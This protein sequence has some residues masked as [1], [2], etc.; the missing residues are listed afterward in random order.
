MGQR[1][2]KRAD[3]RSSRTD[4]ARCNTP[5][6]DAGIEHSVKTHK[7]REIAEQK[8]RYTGH[9]LSIPAD[10]SLGSLAALPPVT[11]PLPTLLDDRP[12]LPCSMQ[13]CHT[14]RQGWHHTMSNSLPVHPSH[15]ATPEFQNTCRRMMQDIVPI[16]VFCTSSMQDKTRTSF[17]K[18]RPM[19]CWI[20]HT[21]YPALALGT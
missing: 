8:T 1:R 3:K 6:D 20:S 9:I 4:F 10:L 2:K 16:N 15:L 14:S 21:P 13:A 7:K 11:I 12:N 18:S 5:T 17:S 19:I